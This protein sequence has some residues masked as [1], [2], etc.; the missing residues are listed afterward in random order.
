MGPSRVFYIGSNN[1]LELTAIRRHILGSFATMPVA[2]EY[3]H[4]NAYE[5]AQTYGKDLYLLIKHAG[6]ERIPAAF[7]L[8]SRFDALT[9]RLGLGSAV[10]DRMLQII[11]RL[12]PEHLP[13]RMNRFRDAYEH[14]LLLR[15][16]GE[17][18]SEAR[19]Y[20]A[21]IFPSATGNFFECDEEE[22]A[23]AF[24]NRY[25]IGGGAV[26]YRAV[27]SDRV[28]NIVALDLAMP[29]NTMD[30][31]DTI[32]ECLEPAIEHRVFCGHF[33]CQVFHYDY[34]V[35]KGEDWLAIEHRI[36]D[37]LAGRGIEFPS[38][39]NVGHLYT[40]KP[41]LADFYRSLDPT[42]SLNPGVGQTSKRRNWA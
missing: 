27:H 34:A 26:R 30:W 33:L 25:A 29:R 21:S 8:K 6:T 16:D 38:E 7:A 14:H 32:P 5:L 13:K 1:H 15:M 9:S 39:H 18:I 3:L 23:A 20:L 35:R 11:T 42:N 10:S 17:G 40:A 41:V 28:E 12:L 37:H 22:G 19:D 4:R 31:R 36:I 24:R 2:G